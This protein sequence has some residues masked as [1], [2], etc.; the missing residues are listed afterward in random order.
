MS[1]STTRPR[2][3]RDAL[4]AAAAFTLLIHLLIWWGAPRSVEMPN[5]MRE[6]DDFQVEYMIEPIPEEEELQEQY[7]RA[8]PDVPDETPEETQN[9]SDRNQLAAQEEEVIPDPDNMPYVEGDM[10]ESNRLVQGD[11]FQQP[12]PPAPP[13]AGEEAAEENPMSQQEPAP[14]DQPSVAAPDAVEWD[15]PIDEDEGMR[16]EPEIATE[17]ETRDEPIDTQDSPTIDETS[18]DDGSGDAQVR[19]PPQQEAQTEAQQPRPR[20][21][22]ERDTS[23]G[24]IRDNRQGAVR[25][26]RLAFDA[27]YSEFGE[28][29]R[30]VAEIIERRW[31][32]LLYNSRSISFS[33]NR[34]VVDFEITRDGRVTNVQIRDSSA[35]RLAESISTDAIVGEAPFFNWTPEMILKMGESTQATIHFFY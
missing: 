12:T 11:P 21:R 1:R 29:W 15:D 20:M 2:N 18:P 32:N 31:R 6:G 17:Q 10:E 35:G 25:I 34:V 3:D 33:G 13:E 19:T 14:A 23:Y 24:P 9:I 26:G 16:F 7:V 22:V 8:T 30:R 5:P 27:Q 4:F 28:Y